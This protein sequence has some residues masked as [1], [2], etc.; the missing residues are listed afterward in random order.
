MLF[1]LGEE[2]GLGAAL[3]RRVGKGKCWPGPSTLISNRVLCV[4][5]QNPLASVP[6][7]RAGGPENA[8]LDLGFQDT[9]LVPCLGLGVPISLCSCSVLHCVGL[10]RRKRDTNSA[11]PASPSS[12]PCT[13]TPPP[14]QCPPTRAV[15]LCLADPHPRP[16]SLKKEL[17]SPGCSDL[18]A[19]RTSWSLKEG[20]DDLK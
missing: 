19:P 8:S 13:P 7:G 18:T 4:R 9:G 6:G 10:R 5:W 16:S 20:G 11:L 1:L 2:R 17:I 12:A 3:P 14:A 15:A